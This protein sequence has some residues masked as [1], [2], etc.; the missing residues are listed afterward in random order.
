MQQDGPDSL[1][2]YRTISLPVVY[3]AV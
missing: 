1:P 2:I 3:T